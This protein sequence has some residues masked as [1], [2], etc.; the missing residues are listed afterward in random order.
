ML[1]YTYAACRCFDELCAAVRAREGAP[2]SFREDAE[3]CR[4]TDGKLAVIAQ[5]LT[6]S[7]LRIAAMGASCR[8]AGVRREGSL[9]HVRM[10][11]I[12]RMRFDDCPSYAEWGIP[13]ACIFDSAAG[14]PVLLDWRSDDG[15]EEELAAR[16]CSSAQ[17]CLREAV[18]Y[19][20]QRVKAPSMRAAA[21]AAR[22]A[23][24]GRALRPLDRE[25]MRTYAL[26]NCSRVHPAGG[27]PGAVY[28]DFSTIP[29]N[30]DCTNFVS[31]AVLAGRA[32]MNK[33]YGGTGVRAEGWYFYSINDRSHSWSGVEPF[34]RFMTTNRARGPQGEGMSFSAY[35]EGDFAE[36]GDI[37]QL[38][39][40]GQEANG[41]WDHS[42]V[43]TGTAGR[44]IRVT[45]RTA[46]GAYGRD[47]PLLLHYPFGAK[48]AIVLAGYRD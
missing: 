25:G 4:H 48:R 22:Y 20:E 45:W 10:M 35:R 36:I 14:R 44:T 33:P 2:P 5:R 8:P 41:T 9:F 23:S 17:L 42:T 27:A 18:R 11:A 12:L 1:E 15:I 21:Q 39:H 30:W 38:D 6:E 40:L 13:V 37:I 43:V 31:H 7:G 28:F 47:I 34:Y 26:E 16:A 32:P 29:G 46:R 3:L 19:E 24:G